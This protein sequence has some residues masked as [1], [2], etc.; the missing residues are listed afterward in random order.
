MP[1]TRRSFRVK[2]APPARCL[3]ELDR[4]AVGAGDLGDD[5]EAEAGAGLT[6]T[7]TSPET[8]KDACSVGGGYTWSPIYTLTFPTGSTVMVTSV[9]GGAWMTAFSMRF[10]SASVTASASPRTCTGAS[11]ASNPKARPRPMAQERNAPRKLLRW[12]AGR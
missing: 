5:G 2:T 6:L 4:S 11:G 3:I 8:L 1:Q 9:P 12:R 10:R 7:S